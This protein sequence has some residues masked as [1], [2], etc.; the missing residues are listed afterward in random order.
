MYGSV[1]KSTLNLVKPNP[2]LTPFSEQNQ[3][4]AWPAGCMIPGTRFD[5][6]GESQERAHEESQRWAGSGLPA[7]N[8]SPI[9]NGLCRADLQRMG[10]VPELIHTERGREYA[11]GLFN[12][13]GFCKCG[14]VTLSF[15]KRVFAHKSLWN[16]PRSNCWA[17]HMLW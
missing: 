7:C 16:N 14:L 9:W 13:G 2:S 11:V 3:R 1:M 6:L 15:P 8:P 17:Q 10:V 12:N 5:W 4:P